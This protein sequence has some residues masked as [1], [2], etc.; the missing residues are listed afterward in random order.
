MRPAW[1]VACIGDCKGC[2]ETR[3]GSTCLLHQGGPPHEV[4][5]G[6]GREG[7]DEA[8]EGRR[9]DLRRQQRQRDRHLAQTAASKLLGQANF[10][11]PEERPAACM[12]RYVVACAKEQGAQAAL[13]WYV[14]W[15]Q[16]AEGC[17]ES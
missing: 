6:L 2:T 10:H 7:A 3:R 1:F 13:A 8:V 11:A 14:Q 17:S 5:L 16:H 4:Q 15:T 12:H 9:R